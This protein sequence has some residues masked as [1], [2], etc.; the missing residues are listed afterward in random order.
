VDGKP[1]I[2]RLIWDSMLSADL[3]HR[4]YSGLADLLQRWDRGARMFLAITSSAAVAGWAVWS[5]A[6]LSWI[7]H[8]ASALA[9]VVAVAQTILDHTKSIKTAGQ[10]AGAWFSI[11][12]DYE[13]LWASV[14]TASGKEVREQCQ[15][16]IREEKRLAELEA[17][18]T[19][20]RQ[21]ARRCEEEVRR[22]RATQTGGQ[23][24]ARQ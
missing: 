18:L 10:L 4:Y 24:D 23:P 22:F 9:A 3:N 8:G 11:L 7:W 17:T 20:R 14:G 5:T 1:E 12:R 19:T 21:V 13:L 6:G 2:R 15:R 16:I